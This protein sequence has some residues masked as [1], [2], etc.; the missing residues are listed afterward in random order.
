MVAH[1]CYV[2]QANISRELL[3]AAGVEV[4][5][6]HDLSYDP[7]SPEE[8]IECWVVGEADVDRLREFGYLAEVVPL[9]HL[10]DH[11]SFVAITNADGSRA[12]PE[13]DPR[14]IKVVRFP[15]WE[16]GLERRARYK[17]IVTREL[18]GVAGDVSVYH[19][20]NSRV[21]PQPDEPADFAL[22]LNSSPVPGRYDLPQ[23]LWGQLFAPMTTNQS[24]VGMWLDGFPIYSQEGVEIGAVG[25]RCA[26]IYLDPTVRPHCGGDVSDSVFVLICQA[27]AEHIRNPMSAPPRAMVRKSYVEKCVARADVERR[28]LESRAKGLEEQIVEYQRGLNEGLREFRQVAGQLHHFEQYVE[29]M[30]Q[31]LGKEFDKLVAMPA[32]KSVS[33]RGSMLVVETRMIYCVDPRTGHEHEIGEIKILI[34][35]ER[36]QVCFRNQTHQIAGLQPDMQAPHVFPTGKACLGNMDQ[37]IPAL[38]A[39]FEWAAAIHMC[40]HF[41]RAVNVD[42]PAGKHIDKWPVHRT[43][44]EIEAERLQTDEDRR[45][46]LA[47]AAETASAEQLTETTEAHA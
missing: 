33:W 21:R 18:T 31:R 5:G 6:Q 17:E 43:A 13:V 26:Y 23:L 42:D 15:E 10:D 22:F 39:K 32:L 40:L 30:R 35:S 4:I 9:D 34:D 27:I 25:D 47:A 38:V 8:K 46:L 37:A 29:D 7:S 36:A 44:E 24:I 45:S 19:S 20:V 3:L 2:M 12:T 11:G 16:A 14:A 1:A 41:L 28:K